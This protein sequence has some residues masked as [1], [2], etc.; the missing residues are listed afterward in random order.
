MNSNEDIEVTKKN[1]KKLFQ[2][3]TFLKQ[4]S[5][6]KLS[7]DQALFREKWFVNTKPS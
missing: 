3:E 2:L 7:D 1:F 4:T 5:Y 6:S